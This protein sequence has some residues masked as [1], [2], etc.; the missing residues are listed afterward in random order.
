M[1]RIVTGFL[2]SVL[3]LLLASCTSNTG[4]SG[5]TAF[6]YKRTQLSYGKDQGVVA[7]EYRDLDTQ[8][9]DVATILNIYVDGPKV[10]ELANVF[11]AECDV[12]WFSVSE[13]TASVHFNKAFGQMQGVSQTLACVCMSRTVMELTGAKIVRISAEGVSLGGKEYLEFN[14]SSVFYFDNSKTLGG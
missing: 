10:T 2:A 13:G 12:L 6:Y 11:P 4:K 3:L 9:A 8:N 14:E 1:K 7:A 5:Q